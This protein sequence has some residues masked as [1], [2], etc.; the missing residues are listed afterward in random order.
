MK[1]PP[2]PIH[3]KGEPN[4][5]ISKNNNL[6]DKQV[7]LPVDTFGGRVH[8]EWDP[9]AAV[10]PLGQL[11]FFIEFLKL[12]NLFD[13]WV[14]DCPLKPEGPNA[15]SARDILGTLLLGVLAGHTRYAHITVL[16]CDG[17]NPGL[18]GIDKIVSEDT[19]R[20]AFVDVEEG[21]A[22]TWLQQHL[23][24]CYSP[25]LSVPWI[26][27]VDT[28]VKPLYG[29][30]EGAVIGYNPQKRGRPSHTYHTYSMANLRLVLEVE[31]HPGN[32]MAA[33]Y[34]APGLWS[35]LERLPLSYW[36]KFLRGDCNFGT[37]GVM[38]EAEARGI[39]YLFKLKSTKNIKHLV[40]RLMGNSDWE[41]AGQGWEGQ[42]S[43]IQ[44]MGW[45]KSRKVIV[46]RKRVGKKDITALT[47]DNC[48]GQLQLNFAEVSSDMPVYEYAVLVT[49]LSGE[50]L[51]IAQHY[52][53]RA[54]SENIFDELK[55]QWGWGGFTTQDLKRCQIMSRNVALIYNWWNLFVR[56]AE[57]NKHLE[58]VTSRRLLLHAVGKQSTHAG[59]TTI[60]ISSTHGQ[61][62][63]VQRLLN[64][65]VTFFQSL[66]ELAEQMTAEERW[67]WILSK[68]VE[69]FLGGRI[70]KPPICLPS[71]A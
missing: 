64:R 54:D 61:I 15:S 45:K 25:L 9:Q 10:T 63:K 60:S 18:L 16:R 13:T 38:T 7:K 69:K 51:T 36:P 43:A 47:E 34:T 62:K 29:K 28:T 56:L 41:S 22:I 17:I 33:S 24:K 2:A 31:V 27:D 23:Y 40:A 4:K 19:M 68:A 48:T 42:E 67:Y 66:K 70:L 35:L 53:D 20:R 52:R 11:P 12:G 32:E 21:A 6:L 8:V 58:A 14:K 71:S 59:Q 26:L 44:L 1:L 3:Q 65:V 37:D 49:S 39:P 46:L 5:V 55:N 30:Q 50:V 57:P